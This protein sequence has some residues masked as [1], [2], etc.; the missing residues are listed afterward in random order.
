MSSYPITPAAELQKHNEAIV[1]FLENTF[2]VE[3]NPTL[4]DDTRNDK[5]CHKA[6]EEAL[7]IGVQQYHL[8]SEES[9][10]KDTLTSSDDLRN[11]SEIANFFMSEQNAEDYS[12]LR[13][14]DILSQMQIV[15]AHLSNMLSATSSIEAAFSLYR[16]GFL[17]VSHDSAE[18]YIHGFKETKNQ[19]KAIASALHW[20]PQF[21]VV[22]IIKL[23]VYLLM[24]FKHILNDA[25]ALAL[26]I[27][28]S[29]DD[30]VVRDYKSNEGGLFMNTGKMS[31]FMKDL[32]FVEG[33]KKDVQLC[34]TKQWELDGTKY[35]GVF[36]GWYFAEKKEMASY[37]TDGVMIFTSTDNSKHVAH[38]FAVPYSTTKGANGVNVKILEA[39]DNEVAK[40][41]FGDLRNEHKKVAYVTKGGLDLTS[42]IS[43]DHAEQAGIILS[44]FEK[45]VQIS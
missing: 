36:A 30:F 2:S 23:I 28:A 1:L 11:C 34:K 33:Q 26:V 5:Q 43:S 32:T 10:L 42:A 14:E 22:S 24:F 41:L 8:N 21:T 12:E 20:A 37:G 29:D 45:D 4:N 9:W 3:L 7:F 18:V 35:K 15:H 27:N 19:F 17:A 44:I 40:S 16:A 31:T 25:K 39:S 38:E 13:G 6:L